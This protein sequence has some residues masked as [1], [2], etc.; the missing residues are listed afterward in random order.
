MTLSKIPYKGTRDY[1][2]EE[3]TVQNYIFAKWREVCESFGYQEYGIP[4]LEPTELY[5]EKSG[6]ELA[7]DQAYSFEDKGGRMVS[8][9]PEATPSVGRLVAQRRQ[10]TAYPARLFS[11]A[12]FMRYERPQKGREREFWQLNVDTFGA[13]SLSY[14]AETIWLAEKLLKV[15]GAT[16]E[17]FSILV[18]HRQLLNDILLNDV[19]LSK[20]QIKPL[21]KLIDS[22]NKMSA[23]AYDGAVSEIVGDDEKKQRLELLLSQ[24]TPEE[25]EKQ[26]GQNLY[27]D[28]LKQIFA[29]LGA[30]GVS[31]A[32]FDLALVRGLD[33]YTGMVFE[34]VDNDPE[35]NRSLFGGGRYD[36]LVEMFGVEPITAVGFALGYTTTELFLRTHGLLP[37]IDAGVD[38]Y[39]AV[40]DEQMATGMSLAENLRKKGY[41]VDVD[42]SSRK[43]DKMIKSADKKL[44]KNFVVVGNNEAQSGNYAYKNLK[45]GK[46]K[47]L[48]SLS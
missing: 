28:E 24:E 8:I 22:K 4:L 20:E 35:N 23:E 16:D 14:D 3:K 2:P 31:S 39:I 42:L 47:S 33:Y 9:R 40:L 41:K 10:E 36:G 18:N 45:T 13:D 19:K 7:S 25:L 37:D 1:F 5:L 15:F 29:L 30:L 43:L 11:I 6:T 26:V 44:A 38:Y 48:D 27:L 32:K 12:N 21:I 17:N 46:T 34:V